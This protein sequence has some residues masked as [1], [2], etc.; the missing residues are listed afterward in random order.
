MVNQRHPTFEAIEDSEQKRPD[1]IMSGRSGPDE[2][3]I[4]LEKV[5]GDDMIKQEAILSEMRYKDPLA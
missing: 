1:T 3:S 2:K 5:N 4:I